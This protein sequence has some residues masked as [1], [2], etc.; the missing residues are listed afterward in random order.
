MRQ[1]FGARWTRVSSATLAKHMRLDLIEAEYA[2][3]PPP[4]VLALRPTLRRPCWSA[5]LGASF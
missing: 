1:S 4:R 5:R 3:L 2:A